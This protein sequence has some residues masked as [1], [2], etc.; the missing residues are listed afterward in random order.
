M[1]GLKEH[2][3]PPDRRNAFPARRVL[4]GM[5][6]SIAAVAVA[7][8]IVWMRRAL[9]IG[10]IRVVMTRQAAAIVPASTISAICGSKTIV[11]WEDAEEFESPHI[12]LT[13][14]ADVFIVMP[15]T[16]NVIAKAANGVADDP[17]TSCLLAAQCPVVFAPAMNAAMW[18]KAAT[19][20]NVAQLEADGFLV[21]R[22]SAR[23]AV[24][25]AAENEA[26]MSDVPT[27][28]RCTASLLVGEDASG[29]DRESLS[30][31]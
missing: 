27:V 15:A 25:D 20:R 9:G 31:D 16:A 3:V 5:S 8:G 17:L 18:R 4:L 12:A 13:K 28:M 26:A 11:N 29:G 2:D 14:W 30:S 23:Y 24:A 7:P 10:A 1:D 21:V 22:P 6:G 19:Q